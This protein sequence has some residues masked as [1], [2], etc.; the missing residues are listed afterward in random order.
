MGKAIASW[1]EDPHQIER[2]PL[3]LIDRAE[4]DGRAYGLR[5]VSA[6]DHVDVP[7]ELCGDKLNALVRR[8][9]ERAAERAFQALHVLKAT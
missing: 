1:R 4:H 8:S 2:E 7:E 9:H 6:A 3:H 5:C